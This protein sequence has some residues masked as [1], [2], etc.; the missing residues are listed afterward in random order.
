MPVFLKSV[1]LALM[2]IV[3]LAGDS[4]AAAAVLKGHVTSGEK[5]ALPANAVAEISLLDVS[6]AD[7][8]SVVIAKTTLQPRKMPFTYRLRYDAAKLNPNMR[9]ALQVRIT[10][11]GELIYITTEHIAVTGKERRV[12]ARMSKVGDEANAGPA[13]W[14]DWV[15][16]SIRGVNQVGKGVSLTLSSDGSVS[17]N[18]GCNRINGTLSVSGDDGLSFGPM[19]STRKMCPP[20]VMQREQAFI[21]ALGQTRKQRVKA[22]DETLYLLDARGKTLAVLKRV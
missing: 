7:A 10:V 17:G 21:A 13:L 11:A 19:A 4:L 15:V 6:L 18:A 16:Q 3:S 2:V 1:F 8:P 14:N 9:Y 5:V 22:A 12:D 20:E